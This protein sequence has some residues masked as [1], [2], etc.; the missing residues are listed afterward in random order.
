MKLREITG[1]GMMTCKKALTEAN[2]DVQLAVEN[3]RKQGQAT[4][5]KR[6]SKIAKE[7]KVEIIL[8]DSDV[9]MYEVNSETDFVARNQ[10]FISFV[11]LLGT[12]LMEKKPKDLTSALALTSPIFNNVTI[13]AKTLELIAKIGEKIAFRRFYR[14][15]I[16]E[17]HER[18]FSYIHGTGKIGVVVIVSSDKSE[19]LGS[20]ILAELGKDLAMQVAAS[21]PIAPNRP[22]VSEAVVA[23][24]KEIYRE[25]VK[26]SGKPETIWEKIIN[27]KMDKFYKQAVITEQEYIRET[28][29]TVADR[30][31]KAN[32][33]L[34]ATITIKSFVRYELGAEE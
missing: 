2:G 34:N 8:K 20:P 12:V 31:K 11:S 18:A 6:S 10:D 25:Q 16:N 22:G 17:T 1:L 9:L 23:K 33:D 13:E 21:K 32:T 30:I 15:S 26:M 29:I 28:E 4:A 5:E 27:G 24:E 7:G 19:T 14:T 3:L